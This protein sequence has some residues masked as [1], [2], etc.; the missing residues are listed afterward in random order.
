MP[1]DDLDVL[2]RRLSNYKAVVFGVDR[3]CPHTEALKRT[4]GARIGTD[5]GYVPCDRDDTSAAICEKAGISTTPTLVFGGVAF[6]GNVPPSRISELLDMSDAIGA[7]LSA[8]HAVLFVRPR[9]TWSTRQ[10]TALGPHVDRIEVV[11]CSTNES[12]C[13][14][15]GVIAVPAWRIDASPLIYGFRPLPSLQQLVSAGAAY[16]SAAAVASDPRTARR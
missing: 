12:R 8:K 14:A 9:C 5:I 6:A 13:D 16:R 4:W 10:R 1:A 15:D 2:A 7:D 3:G 11:D